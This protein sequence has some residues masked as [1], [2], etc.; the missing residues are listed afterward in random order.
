MNV[1]TSDE[2]RQS[3]AVI[4]PQRK[5]ARLPP[6]CW[7]VDGLTEINGRNLEIPWDVTVVIAIDRSLIP[8][9]ALRIASRG[10]VIARVK[11]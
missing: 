2:A 4:R 6:N 10:A 7:P 5:A 3:C 8:A 11:R 9:S 1:L